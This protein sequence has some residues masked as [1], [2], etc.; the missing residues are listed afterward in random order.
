MHIRLFVAVVFVL[1]LAAVACETKDGSPTVDVAP[2]DS[3]PTPVA[4]RLPATTVSPSNDI[5][6]HPLTPVFPQIPFRPEMVPTAAPG[7]EFQFERRTDSFPADGPRPFV[8]INWNVPLPLAREDQR[9][10]QDLLAQI[11]DTPENRS[12]LRLGD[13]AVW[14]SQVGFEVPSYE[15]GKEAF[16]EKYLDAIPYYTSSGEVD[17]DVPWPGQGPYLSGFTDYM[18]SLQTFDPLGF[19]QRNVDQTVIAAPFGSDFTDI[20]VGR[21]DPALA[22]RL[23]AECDCP[24]PDAMTAYGGYEY[25]SWGDGSGN[26]RRW[27][28]P[29]LL[30][31]FGR[32]GHVLMTES[33]LYRTVTVPLMEQLIDTLNGKVPSLAQS[34]DFVFIMDVMGANIANGIRV[35]SGASFARE[36]VLPDGEGALPSS[37]SSRGPRYDRSLESNRTNAMLAPLLLP[38]ESVTAGTGW[39][40]SHQFDVLVIVNADETTATA[41]AWRLADRVVNSNSS[42]GLPWAVKYPKVDISVSGKYLVAVFRDGPS[43]GGL[44]F[45]SETGQVLFVHE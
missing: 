13:H 10:L 22:Q 11:P 34:A 42:D 31:Q 1:M 32:G 20:I 41:N 23:L 33:G 25:W 14:R 21:Y 4:T 29:P 2:S 8:E 30:D 38:Y 37:F 24:Q 19:D 27:F 15:D 6:T 43:P 16:I 28:D 44:A 39:D 26:L 3:S 35:E 9:T 18:T 5:D 45:G 12:E 7:V 40:G 17:P 36:T